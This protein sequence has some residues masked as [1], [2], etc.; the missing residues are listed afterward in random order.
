MSTPNPVP[1]S[2]T[3]NI[4]V[5]GC[6][7][8]ARKGEMIIRVTDAND[9]YIPRFCYHEKLPVAANCRM[10]LVE[11]EKAP[12][13][14]P[15]CATPVAEGMVIHTKSPKAIAAQRAVMEFLLIN[16]PLDCP[17]CDQ[18]GECEL[19]DLAIGYGR[20]SVQPACP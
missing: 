6:P 5:D 3:V 7:M 20:D 11:V 15:A 12:K 18:G 2:D 19:Q 1:P 16:H 8:K 4:T 14:L 10:C 9:V 13:P 17:I